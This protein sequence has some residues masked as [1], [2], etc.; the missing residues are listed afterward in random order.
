MFVNMINMQKIE[1]KPF[2]TITVCNFVILYY[3][4][5]TNL[6]CFCSWLLIF[7]CDLYG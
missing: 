6:Y 7:N 4:A 5:G 3:T 2:V 1:V